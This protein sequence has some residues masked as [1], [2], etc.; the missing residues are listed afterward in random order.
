MAEV[1]KAKPYKF[2]RPLPSFEERQRAAAA[3]KDLTFEERLEMM[4]SR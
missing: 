2:S 3:A 1:L 4:R